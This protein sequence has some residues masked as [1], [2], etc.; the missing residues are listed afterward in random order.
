MKLT[1]L[2][3]WANMEEVFAI[4]IRSIHA[5]WT[6]LWE[7]LQKVSDLPVDISPGQR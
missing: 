1:A 2:A 4:I 7:H 6:Y 3:R 5:K